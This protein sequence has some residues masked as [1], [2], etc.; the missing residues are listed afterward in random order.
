MQSRTGRECRKKICLGSC[1]NHQNWQAPTAVISA[2]LWRACQ[3]KANSDSGRKN[4][5]QLSSALRIRDE[6]ITI[7]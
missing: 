7:F 1:Y 4:A 3:L 6:I 2:S 5:P